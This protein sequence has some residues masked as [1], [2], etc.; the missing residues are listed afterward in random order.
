MIP[1]Q[2]SQGGLGPRGKRWSIGLTVLCIGWRK[3]ELAAHGNVNR[4]ERGRPHTGKAGMVPVLGDT[5]HLSTLLP[6]A[7]ELR[8]PQRGTSPAGSRT[9]ALPLVLGG[10]IRGE[11]EGVLLQDGDEIRD[12][13][14]EGSGRV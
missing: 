13:A 4:V 3:P 6:G 11:G 12:R 2:E 9:I 8:P 10:M 1:L 7:A 14:A 5:S